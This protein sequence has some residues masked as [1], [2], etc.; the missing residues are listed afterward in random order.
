M[1]GRERRSRLDIGYPAKFRPD[2]KSGHVLWIASESFMGSNINK[3]AVIDT[4][5][6]VLVLEFPCRWHGWRRKIWIVREFSKEFYKNSVETMRRHTLNL[7]FQWIRLKL[8]VC[9]VLSILMFLTKINIFTE[10]WKHSSKTYCEGGILH[11]FN[12]FFCP[13]NIRWWNVSLC[14]HLNRYWVN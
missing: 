7:K 14:L 4:M 13:M 6:R 3:W 1:L 10:R 11:S 2:Y 9:S 8:V 5:A 12:F